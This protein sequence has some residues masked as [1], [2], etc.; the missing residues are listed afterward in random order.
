MARDATFTPTGGVAVPVTDRRAAP[1]TG[2]QNFRGNAPPTRRRPSSTSASPMRPVSAKATG[3][4]STVFSYVVQGG[5][6]PGR[7]ATDL[8]GG[9]SQCMRLSATIIGD[10]G[11][12][13]PR[14]SGPPSRPFRKALARRPRGSRPSS[15]RRLPNAGARS[16]ACQNLAIGRPT[17]KGQDSITA[18]GLVWSESAGHHPRLREDGATI[19]SKNGFFLAIPTA[20]AGRLWGRWPQDYA[21]RM[22]AADGQRCRFWSIAATPP[23]CSSPTNMRARKRGKRGGYSRASAAAFAERKGPLLTVTD[24]HSGAAGDG[25]ETARCF[26]SAANAGSIA[27]PGLV[28]RNWFFR[29]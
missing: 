28:T 29:R 25:P 10:L 18:A 17:P 21:R 11:A 8:D 20:A 13:W 2:C 27:C 7:G 16:P 22:G 4:S 3:S 15:G 23:L 19:R 6:A 5:T 12:S 24:I 9:A 26:V 1:Q 14:R